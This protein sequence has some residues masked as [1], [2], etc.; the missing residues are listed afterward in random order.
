LS[1]GDWEGVK[2]G[3]SLGDWEGFKDG[4]SLGDSEGFKDGI[5]LGSLGSALA[6]WNWVAIDKI[7][8]E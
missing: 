5:S 6:N 2:D 4:T 3:L 7:E 1:E 8:T